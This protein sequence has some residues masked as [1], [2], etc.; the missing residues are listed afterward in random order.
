MNRRIAWIT[1]ASSGIGYST[2]KKLAKQ[3][4]DLYLGAR[5]VDRLDSLVKDIKNSC[6]VRAL[7][8]ELDVTDK[9]SVQ[10]FGDFGFAKQLQRDV[11]VNNAG[12]VKGIDPVVN[13]QEQD[14]D[15]ILNTN[16]MGVLRMAKLVLPYMIEKKNGQIVFIGSIAGHQAYAGG[17][18][19]C[20]SKFGV[21]AITRSLKQEVL[22]TNIRVNSIDPGMVET[23]FSL[24]RLGSQEKA[25]NV[26][27]GMT[28]LTADD[29][30]D[31]VE[32]VV[33]RPRHVN[34]DDIV[35]MPTDQANAFMVHRSEP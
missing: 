27:K 21:K 14:W 12:L 1:G 18:A 33:N 7:S 16:V 8:H 17:S 28:P 34:I 20:A 26:Y 29:V 32:F 24:V 19:Y 30:A 9:D 25:D 35:I 11:L 22:G 2:A 4:F 5:R 10:K 31:C 23:E 13:G 15:I 6:D 3:G